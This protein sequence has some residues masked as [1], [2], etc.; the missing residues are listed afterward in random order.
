VASLKDSLTKEQKKLNQAL[1]SIQNITLNPSPGVVHTRIDTVYL[2]LDSIVVPFMGET[3]LFSYQGKLRYSYKDHLGDHEFS[4]SPK[5]ILIRNELFR[6]D[7]GRWF[8]HTTSQ[9]PSLGISQETILDSDLIVGKRPVIVNP[10]T[11]TFM[12]YPLVE[13]RR[14][15]A[16]KSILF[17]G[18]LRTKWHGFYL[19]LMTRSVQGGVELSGLWAYKK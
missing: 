7:K 8:I 2:S 15:Y 10:K 18:G 3:Y 17:D 19:D 4:F 14:E 13:F 16:K 12:I 5:T 1:L 6:D 9:N 11:P